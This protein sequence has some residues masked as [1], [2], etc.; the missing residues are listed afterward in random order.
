[1]Q[2][3]APTAELQQYDDIEPRSV[4]LY[5]ELITCSSSV[6]AKPLTTDGHAKSGEL[7]PIITPHAITKPNSAGS[8]VK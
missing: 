5:V 1:M 8:A 3:H 4:K 7:S 6:N 2:Q